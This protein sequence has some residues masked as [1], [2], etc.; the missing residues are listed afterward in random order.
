[1]LQSM[2]SQRVKLDWAIEQHGQPVAAVGPL[3]S[4]GSKVGRSQEAGRGGELP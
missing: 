2:G 3:I 1:M 4:L